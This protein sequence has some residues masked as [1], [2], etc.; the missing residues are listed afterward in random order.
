MVLVPLYTLRRN[1][2]NPTLVSIVGQRMGYEFSSTTRR[3]FRVHVGRLRTA[4][5]AISEHMVFSSKALR[6]G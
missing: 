3:T 2:L 1:D 6:K 4:C 5:L